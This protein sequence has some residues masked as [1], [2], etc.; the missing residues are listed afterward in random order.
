MIEKYKEAIEHFNESLK[1][2]PNDAFEL[3]NQGATLRVL[4]KY[5]EW[6]AKFEN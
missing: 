1:I 5:E 6:L 3:R 4:G 2:E